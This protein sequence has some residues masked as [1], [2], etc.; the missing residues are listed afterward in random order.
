MKQHKAQTIVGIFVVLVILALIFLAFKVSGL[1]SISGHQGYTVTA[2]F[3]NIG[4]LKV[5]APVRI[6]GVAVG[7][8]TD[9]KLDP[10]TFNAVVVMDIDENQQQI[11]VDTSASIF[12][13]GL[14]GANYVN[15]TPGYQTTYLGNG[16]HIK[17]TKSALILENLIGQLLFNVKK[18]S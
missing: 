14:L 5:R 3:N 12:T 17:S 9:I 7:Y 16:G 10:T 11:P 18:G 4:G 6:S 8:V 1:T 2:S 15:L 13:E